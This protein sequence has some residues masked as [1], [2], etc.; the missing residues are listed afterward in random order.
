MGGSPGKS[1]I[2]EIVV[3]SDL[4]NNGDN[5]TDEEIPGKFAVFPPEQRRRSSDGRD[6]AD[7][8]KDK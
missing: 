7:G 5:Y 8:P 2:T 6:V 3:K 1:L 4:K